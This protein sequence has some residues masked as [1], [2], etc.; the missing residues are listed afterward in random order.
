VSASSKKTFQR[1]FTPAPNRLNKH[2]RKVGDPGL[3]HLRYQRSI[4]KHA[5]MHVPVSR[6]PIF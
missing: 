1:A 2:E 5:E 6:L 3:A 4:R